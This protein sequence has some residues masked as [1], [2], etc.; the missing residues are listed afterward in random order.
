ME[1]ITIDTD[2][3]LPLQPSKVPFEDIENLIEKSE[4]TGNISNFPAVDVKNHADNYLVLRNLETAL[5]CHIYGTKA[6]ACLW[7]NMPEI[8]DVELRKQYKN[9]ELNLQKTREIGICTIQDLLDMGKFQEYVTQK[10]QDPVKKQIKRVIN[11]YL[12]RSKINYKDVKIEQDKVAEKKI[13]IKF[14][15][16][17]P[18]EPIS[19]EYNLGKTPD[20]TEQDFH[21]YS[22][23]MG[24]FFRDKGN[25]DFFRNFLRV[26]TTAIKQAGIKGIRAGLE[27]LL[28]QALKRDKELKEQHLMYNEVTCNFAESEIETALTKRIGEELRSRVV[29]KNISEEYIKQ[30]A[31]NVAKSYIA[32]LET[33][34]EYPWG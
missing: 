10:H 6:F 16:C 7:E 2:L 28:S 29:L 1:V 3:L 34:K 33:A 26:M 22:V 12:N 11:R 9:S 32:A 13:K 21:F 23:I 19:E 31:E 15:R 25:K 18:P 24:I 14:V 17:N 8:E 27:N 5:A 20:L 30:I 4:I